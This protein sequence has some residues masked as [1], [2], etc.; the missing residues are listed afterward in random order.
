MRVI[1]RETLEAFWR[2]HRDSSLELRQWLAIVAAA[3]WRDL[4]DVRRV[5]ARADTVTAPSRGRLTVFHIAAD[6][7][8][9]LAR[10]KHD[11]QLVSIRRVLTAG[12]YAGGRWED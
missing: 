8:R 11:W 10:I 3:D 7:Y 1:G 2:R 5:F 9:L 4:D 6:K 12:E